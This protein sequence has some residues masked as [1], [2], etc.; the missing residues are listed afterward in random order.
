MKRALV[1]LLV[2]L[3]V[4]PAASTLAQSDG[5]GEVLTMA[6]DGTVTRGT[7]LH[8]RD[9]IDE[10]EERDAPLVIRLDTPGGL[11]S[12][13]LDINKAI[14]RAEVPV[15][16]YVGPRGG[17]AESA[18]T[19]ILLMGHPNGMAPSTQ[20]G[21]AQ[22]ILQN[23][24]GGIENAS[25]KVTNFLVGQIRT[26][27]E[28]NDRN[29]T[30]AEEFIT[31]NRNM[32]QTEARA[33]GMTD[34]VAPDLAAFI[35]AVHGD[36]ARV[37]D[38]LVTLD[39]QDARIVEIEK[40]MLAQLVDLVSNPQIAFVLFLVGLYGVIFGLAAPGTFVPET[41]GA[42][43]LVLGL[44]GLGLFDTSTSGL[45]L[46]LL[47]GVFFVAEIFTPTH[48]ILTTAG[49]A[50]LILGAIFL[51]D[52]PLLS[53]GFLETFR[54]VAIVSAVVS[55]GVVMGAVWVAVRTRSHPVETEMIGEQGR[56]V[57]ALDPEGKV[58][59]HGELWN[60]VSESG[61]TILEDEEVLV[62]ERDGL[63]VTVRRRDAGTSPDQASSPGTSPDDQDA[64]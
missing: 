31:E 58:W 36:Q 57:E 23:P 11:V 17:F 1:P 54:L 24:G 3:M 27:A 21:S 61:D 26:I 28:R 62:T 34:H 16:T 59:L 20:I 56:T 52:E 55:G 10:A 12:A 37:G 19:F 64:A 25:S 22:P 4:L 32:N 63:T 18:G 53:R 5:G 30:I 45:V 13:T 44:I 9:A 39:T 51:L 33:T 40:G 49:V 29:Q 48:G 43:M 7:A 14:T 47:G 60:A 8:V 2:A 38:D 42:L 6:I 46:V 35:E 15:M 50:A 41:I